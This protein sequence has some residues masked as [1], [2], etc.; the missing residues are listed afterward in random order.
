MK[1]ESNGRGG[2]GV[3]PLHAAALVQIVRPPSLSLGG[4]TDAG[5]DSCAVAVPIHQG[6]EMRGILRTR[7]CIALHFLCLG[8]TRWK[9]QMVVANGKD[10]RKRCE[11]GRGEANG[12]DGVRY[13]DCSSTAFGLEGV[14]PRS[15]S[16][17]RLSV[18]FY[19]LDAGGPACLAAGSAR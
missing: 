1:S 8:S 6:E 12:R 3:T 14:A 11:E 19:F 4:I 16:S 18:R 9:R 5:R 2:A 13:G 17:P 10:R 7:D 15:L